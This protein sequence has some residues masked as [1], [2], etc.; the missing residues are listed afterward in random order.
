MNKK[1]QVTIFII[2][3]LIIIAGVILFFTFRENV[4][5]KT[6]YPP[7]TAGIYNFVEECIEQKGEEALYFIGQHGGYYFTPKPLVSPGIPF[8]LISGRNYSPSKEKIENEISKYI[9]DA[10]LECINNFTEFKEYQIEQGEIKTEMLSALKTLR[11][12]Y[13]HYR[14]HILMI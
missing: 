3:A 9:N 8:Y 7:K 2:I 4:S 13:N 14:K 6:D 10:L 11:D 1:A 12:M 5:E